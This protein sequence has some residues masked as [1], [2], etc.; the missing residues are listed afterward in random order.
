[1][2]VA[3]KLDKVEKLLSLWKDYLDDVRLIR[4]SP[5]KGGADNSS[6]TVESYKCAVK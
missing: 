4:I 3:S 6:N 5:S 1:M 2:Y